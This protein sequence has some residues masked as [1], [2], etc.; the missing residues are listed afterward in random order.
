VDVQAT[1]YD[2]SYHDVDSNELSFKISGLQAFKDA[3]QKARP[4]LLEPVMNVAVIVPDQYMGDITGDLNHRRGRIMGVEP[5]DGLQC[6]KAQV[7]QS[8]MFKYCSELRSMTGGRGS[9]EMEFSH[10]ETVP[11]HIA[12]KVVAEA[13]ATKKAQQEA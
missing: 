7:P 8:E 5:A 11:S 1:V 4:V 3:M 10:F 13:A 6:I 2:G 12:Q 9:F